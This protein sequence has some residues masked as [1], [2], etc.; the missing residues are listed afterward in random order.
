MKVKTYISGFIPGLR[1]TELPEGVDRRVTNPLP[2]LP[3]QLSPECITAMQTVHTQCGDPSALFATLGETTE[4]KILNKLTQ[5][6]M[7]ELC[8][9]AIAD[10][11]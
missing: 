10:V 9:Y 5:M 2:V 3:D 1:P 4:R 7:R 11:K 8:R 6:D